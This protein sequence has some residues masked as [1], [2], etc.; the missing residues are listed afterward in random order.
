MTEQ[1][2][3][4]RQ[5]TNVVEV[6]GIAQ[7][8]TL[9]LKVYNDKKTGAP[10]NAIKGEVTVKI[11]EDESQVV[12]YFTK[13]LTKKGE[14]SKNFKSLTTIMNEMVTIADIAQGLSEGEPSRI[15]CQGKLT[16]NEFKAS[17]GEVVSFT[18][19]SGEYSPQRYKGEAK[20]FVPKATYNVEGIVKS[21][22]AEVDKDENETGRLKISLY[23]PLYGGKVIPLSFVTKEDLS[24]GNKDYLMDNFIARASVR[25]FGDLVNKTKKIE[26]VIEVGF[27]ENHIETTYER[28]REFVAKSG[29]LYEE[30]VNKEVFDVSLLKEALANR[31]R[32]L[33]TLK[34][35]V[36]EDK[37]QPTGFGGASKSTQTET[38][39]QEK[40]D[41]GLEDLF[42]ED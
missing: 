33:A 37:P 22:V 39:P 12:S 25:V 38:K 31:N 34:E 26:R 9:E 8:S 14:V 29:V 17:D 27:G 13:E 1:K 16:L 3:L 18:Q 24:Q 20:D 19:I 21:T 10:Y 7:E 4:L 15:E 6:V 41:D 2:Q 42:G 5:A 32:D 36:K 40:K 28:T 23:V 30:G 35:Q 11:S